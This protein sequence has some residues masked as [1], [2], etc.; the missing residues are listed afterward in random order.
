MEDPICSQSSLGGVERMWRVQGGDENLTCGQDHV[1]RFYLSVI[2]DHH[3]T[4]ALR[5]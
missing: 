3:Q 2:W 1:S 4:I 5:S